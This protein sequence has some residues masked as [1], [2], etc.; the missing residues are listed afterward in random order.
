M[1]VSSP[2]I[3]AE[4][5]GPPRGS[6]DGLLHAVRRNRLLSRAGLSERLFAHLFNGLV[7]AQIWEDPEVDMEALRIR[8]GERV[9]TI[10]S[11]GCNALS[12]LAADPG[13]VEAVDLN[14]SHVA[15]TRLKLAALRHLPDHRLLY[16]FLSG[17]AGAPNIAV[18]ER[19]IRPQLEPGA[20][21]FWEKRGL[22][23][24]RR[25]AAFSGNPY[26]HGLLGLFIGSA[27][28]IARLYGVEP[29]AMLLAKTVGEQRAFFDRE[30]APL[31][32]KR[33][34]RWITSRK[35]SLFGLGIPP[36]QYESLASAGAGA[37]R[38][39]CASGSKGLPAR[40]RWRRTISPGRR[41]AGPMAPAARCPPI[42]RRGTSRCFANAPAG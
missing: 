6:L 41:S 42:S 4:P 20:R 39:C 37:W 26:R 38:R 9:V 40:S 33:L 34:I 1:S 29:R 14:A 22:N 36:Q 19:Y 32:D 30:L 23:G 21:A 28:R 24:R 17:E 35:A 3:A 27:H 8:P 7:Y 2:T 12:Y 18:Y 16:G 31:F 5:P 25:I 13:C 15:L 11:G 10:A